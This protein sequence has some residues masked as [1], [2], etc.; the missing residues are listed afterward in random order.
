MSYETLRRMIFDICCDEL[1]DDEYVFFDD[2]GSTLESK[3]FEDRIDAGENPRV[4]V[5]EFAKKIVDGRT[6]TVTIEGKSYRV[7]FTSNFKGEVAS[8]VQHRHNRNAND[9]QIKKFRAKAKRTIICIAN[10]EEI[11]A[12]GKRTRFMRNDDRIKRGITAHEGWRWLY[13]GEKIKSV[14][15]NGSVLVQVAFPDQQKEK[16][17]PNMIYNVAVEG[18]R[19]FPSRE[20]QFRQHLAMPGEVDVVLD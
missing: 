1:C 19:Y 15:A 12:K 7:R 8:K 14:G 6:W 11:L 4:V 9:R 10:L 3:P 18:N 2:I 5:R 17:R 20:K 13:F 16:G